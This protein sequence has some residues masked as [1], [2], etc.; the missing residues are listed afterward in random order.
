MTEDLWRCLEVVLHSLHSNIGCDYDDLNFQPPSILETLR[1][2]STSIDPLNNSTPTFTVLIGDSRWMKFQRLNPKL[3][4]QTEENREYAGIAS[5]TSGD[6]N[7]WKGICESIPMKNH[8]N[9]P[10]VLPSAGVISSSGMKASPMPRSTHQR[11][12]HRPQ[13]AMIVKMLNHKAT[14]SI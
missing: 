4:Q 10:A 6:T 13:L 14:R 2:S 7:T 11:S 1:F 3:L 12:N 9:A 8:T 5:V